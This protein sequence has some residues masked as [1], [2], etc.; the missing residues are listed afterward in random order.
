MS[1]DDK[2]FIYEQ[3]QYSKDNE[4]IM[5]NGVD[6]SKCQIHSREK[7]NVYNNIVGTTSICNI[8]GGY[9]ENKP[10]CRFKQLNRKND[11]Y[12]KDGE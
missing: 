3:K 11:Y 7:I 2:D 10:Y 1:V 4:K 6:V 8:D 9:C 5:C 12:V